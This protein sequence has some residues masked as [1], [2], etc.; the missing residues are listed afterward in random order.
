MLG[1]QIG[2]ERVKTLVD[3]ILKPDHGK[4]ALNGFPVVVSGSSYP[5]KPLC[6]L[7]GSAGIEQV[8]FVVFFLFEILFLLIS[9]I[10]ISTVIILPHSH[11]EFVMYVI[12]YALR[13][14]TVGQCTHS[15]SWFSILV[16]SFVAGSDF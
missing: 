13:N 3:P 1:R 15:A 6:F 4:I 9:Y 10:L 11:L 7:C 8:F 16:L 2:Q 14:P 5:P 12:T